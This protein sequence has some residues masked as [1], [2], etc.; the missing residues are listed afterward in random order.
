MFLGPHD[1]IDHAKE[2]PG[3]TC[4]VAAVGFETTA[5]VYALLLQEAEKAGLENVRLVS[6]LK[7]E[8]VVD[9]PD[10]RH[11]RIDMP[12]LLEAI[13]LEAAEG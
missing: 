7:R 11:A 9:T 2:H 1:V 8:G 12:A 4:V 10:V 6:A 3:E 5:P 13:R